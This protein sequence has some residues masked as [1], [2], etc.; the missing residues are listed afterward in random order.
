M[1]YLVPKKIKKKKLIISLKKINF[2]S[3]KSE[4]KNEI[5][6]ENI[7]KIKCE[8]IEKRKKLILNDII[9]SSEKGYN[10]LLN[11]KVIATNK[12]KR[13]KDEKRNQFKT[14][15]RGAITVRTSPAGASPSR[16]LFAAMSR[17]R[18]TSPMKLP[19]ARRA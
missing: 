15:D 1:N 2:S 17:Q 5:N 10:E 3:K 9:P 12:S 7:E 8:A 16:V 14:K 6:D 13:S 19:S 11:L 4:K 18:A